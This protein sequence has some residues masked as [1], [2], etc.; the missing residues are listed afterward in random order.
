MAE[1]VD[2]VT[3]LRL[4]TERI[5]N[6]QKAALARKELESLVVPSVGPFEELLYHINSVLWDVEDRLRDLEAKEDFGPDFVLLARSVYF[7]N[8]LRAQVKARI[9]KILGEQVKEVKSYIE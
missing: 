4:K 8:D 7:T 6:P 1:L 3:I 9:S 2:K 5:E